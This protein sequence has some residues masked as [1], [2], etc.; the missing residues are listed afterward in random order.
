MRVGTFGYIAESNRTQKNS[1]VAGEFIG[2]F[3]KVFY[4]RD[5]NNLVQ[6]TAYFSKPVI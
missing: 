6:T 3:D 5:E 2:L 1:R 4:M